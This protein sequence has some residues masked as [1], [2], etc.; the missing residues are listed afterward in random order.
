MKYEKCWLGTY[1][2]YVKNCCQM[3]FNRLVYF[4]LYLC[5]NNYMLVKNYK[6]LNVF[7][8]SVKSLKITF[9]I[10]LDCLA[11]KFFFNVYNKTN[12]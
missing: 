5:F 6:I 11:V 10:Y 3:I 12:F 1:Y 9:K 4:N 8:N 2:S 7:N